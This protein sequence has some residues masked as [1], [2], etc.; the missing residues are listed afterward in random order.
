MLQRYSLTPALRKVKTHAWVARTFG[1]LEKVEKALP[2]G[3]TVKVN[4]VS[5]NP[6]D[7]WMIKTGPNKLFLLQVQLTK[8]SNHKLLFCVKIMRY[9]L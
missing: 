6:I 4:A 7:H 8:Y 1:S 9:N 3:L 5:L 2:P